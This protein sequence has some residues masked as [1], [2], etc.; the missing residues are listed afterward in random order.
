MAGGG[1]SP[2]QAVLG[3]MGEQSGGQTGPSGGAAY[4][5]VQANTYSPTFSSDQKGQ[6]QTGLS[7]LVQQMQQQNSQMSPFQAMGLGVLANSL[8][9]QTSQ[10]PM[11]RGLPTYNSPALSYRPDMSGITA[12]LKRV[13]PSV[14]EQQRLAAEAEAKRLAEEAANAPPPTYDYSG[15]SA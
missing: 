7:P 8:F 6:T 10:T 11:Q 2:I 5:P 3:Q 4:T 14:Q 1:G 15:G 9:S 13:A 12:N